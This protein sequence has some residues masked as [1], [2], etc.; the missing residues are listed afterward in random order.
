MKIVNGSWSLDLGGICYR[1]LWELGEMLA[2]LGEKGTYEGEKVDL[3]GLG[4]EFDAN[5]G[6]VYLTE[7]GERIGGEDV[8]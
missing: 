4:A 7:W 6:D 5:T 3:E 8:S 1:E 2:E